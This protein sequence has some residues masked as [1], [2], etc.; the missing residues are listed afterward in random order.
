[1]PAG[2]TDRRG[3]LRGARVLVVEDEFLLRLELETL[4]VQA[5]ASVRTCGTVA[6]ALA[7]VDAET[8]SAAVLDVRLGRETIE[9][10]ARKLAE[11]GVPI[12]FYTGQVAGEV[13]SAH[14]PQA[15]VISKPAPPGMV[16]DAVIES[17]HGPAG[18]GSPDP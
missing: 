16:I 2:E 7:A 17:M 15:R 13:T 11:L 3:L 6:Q 1:M 5:G 8:F 18:R 4:L 14:W 9:S 10:V 12:V